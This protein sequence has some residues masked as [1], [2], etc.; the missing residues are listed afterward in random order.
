MR[1]ARWCKQNRATCADALVGALR[2]CR[3]SESHS[4]LLTGQRAFFELDL[5]DVLSRHHNQAYITTTPCDF[6]GW[7]PG[8]FYCFANG[9]CRRRT[10]LVSKR[11][12]DVAV[13]PSSVRRSFTIGEEPTLSVHFICPPK[14]RPSEAWMRRFLPMNCDNQKVAC[15]LSILVL[16][17]L[18]L[19]GDF[20]YGRYQL[21][22]FAVIAAIFLW[23]LC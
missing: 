19:L 7:I 11:Q 22:R 12:D 3:G 13:L 17:L 5:L 21:Y 23:R 14:T 6:C 10:V 9:F 20:R 8:L 15:S 1:K 16:V 4:A 18:S 2:S